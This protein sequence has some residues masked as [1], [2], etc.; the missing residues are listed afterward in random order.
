[1]SNIEA[2][3]KGYRPCKRCRPE[4]SGGD[5][6]ERRQME[7]VERLKKELLK[8]NDAGGETTVTKIAKDMNVSMWHMNR[9]FKKV[10]GTSPKV[11]AQ[12]Q[13]AARDLKKKK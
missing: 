11:W 10:V 2:E 8:S 12:E 9:L 4:E 13:L 5:P 7:V 3:Q 6:I 1:M